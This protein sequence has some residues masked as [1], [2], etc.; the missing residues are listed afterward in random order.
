MTLQNSLVIFISCDDL[1]NCDPKKAIA[2]SAVLP[3]PRAM[4]EMFCGRAQWASDYPSLIH[5]M[6]MIRKKTEVFSSVAGSPVFFF[7]GMPLI[8]VRKDHG[9]PNTFGALSM[10]LCI[11][12]RGTMDCE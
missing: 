5:A 2:D 1:D 3:T 10:N 8:S 9:P 6:F 7:F 11:S 4:L 12:S